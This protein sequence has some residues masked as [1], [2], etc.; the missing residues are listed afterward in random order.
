MVPE[1]AGKRQLT[2]DDKDKGVPEILEPILMYLTELKLDMAAQDD[3]TLLA[4][5]FTGI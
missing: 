3:V 5:A 2:E 4:I 1:S